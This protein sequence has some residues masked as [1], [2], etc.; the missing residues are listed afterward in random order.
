[1]T[2]VEAQQLIVV[3]STAWPDGQRF[4]SEEQQAE[5]QRMYVRFLLD[6]PYDAAN[7]ALTRLIAA[8]DDERGRWP[9]I[10]KLR[11]AITTQ[12]HGRQLASSEAWGVVLRLRTPRE[13]AYWRA[14]D[15]LVRRCCEIQGWLVRDIVTRAGR[16]HPRQRVVLGENEAADRARFCEMYDQLARAEV[17]D[18]AVGQLAPPVPQRRIGESSVADAVRLALPKARR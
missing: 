10:A 2:E 18:R 15:P 7:V 12:M 13:A 5:T 14:V 17:C 16:D 9:S 3:M 6:L 11:R 8:E 4:L 1:M